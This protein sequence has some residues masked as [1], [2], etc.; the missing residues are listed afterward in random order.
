MKPMDLKGSMELA[1]RNLVANLCSTRHYLPYWT[2]END[3]GY[4]A[5]ARFSWPQHNVGR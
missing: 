3:A 2:I 1:S 5:C 4:G